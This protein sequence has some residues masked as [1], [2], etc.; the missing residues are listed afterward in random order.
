MQQFVPG[1][2]AEQFLDQVGLATII[3]SIAAVKKLVYDDKVLTM[4][5]I[6]KAIDANFE[7]YEVIQQMML[8]APK[9]GLNDPYVDN[10]GKEL[11]KIVWNYLDKHRRRAWRI[12]Q[13]SL[14]TDYKSHLFWK[15]HWCDAKWPESWRVFIRRFSGHPKDARSQVQQHYCCPI[16]IIKNMTNH[17]AMVGY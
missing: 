1:S 16:V 12:Y 15:N 5:D 8:N 14:D 13:C 7:G 6:V 10:I 11:D 9:F 3:D 2:L 17:I 4:E